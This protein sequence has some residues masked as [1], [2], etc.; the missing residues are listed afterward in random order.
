MLHGV[1][2]TLLKPQLGA[3]GNLI[4]D[5]RSRAKKT[6]QAVLDIITDL[7]RGFT[8]CYRRP[9]DMAIFPN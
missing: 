3:S 5:K 6:F 4:Y 2:V 9:S 7:S 8:W 1:G